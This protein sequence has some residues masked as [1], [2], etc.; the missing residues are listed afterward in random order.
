MTCLHRYSIRI[1]H[2]WLLAADTKIY[3]VVLCTN[4]L[5][6][7]QLPNGSG[8]NPFPLASQPKP[9]VQQHQFRSGRV[10]AWHHLETHSLHRLTSMDCKWEFA[11]EHVPSKRES[12]QRR[13]NG[14]RDTSWDNIQFI[15]SQKWGRKQTYLFIILDSYFIR[16]PS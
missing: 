13:K 7:S 14:G 10:I 12:S 15:C 1:Q 8:V 4:L 11:E 6:S 2:L 5:D 9:F 3:P 16:Q